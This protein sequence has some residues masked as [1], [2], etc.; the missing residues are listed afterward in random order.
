MEHKFNEKASVANELKYLK[1]E[2]E[3]LMNLIAEFKSQLNRLKIEE[4]A[5]KA[6]IRDE[7][8]A[9]LLDSNKNDENMND[10]SFLKENLN[11]D[12]KSTLKALAKGGGFFSSEDEDD[13][14]D[15]D[16]DDSQDD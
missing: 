6:A 4:L 15:D 1:E 13:D 16:D 11:L 12:V 5:L 3:L 14:D 8:V 7:N 2:E 9:N 10:E